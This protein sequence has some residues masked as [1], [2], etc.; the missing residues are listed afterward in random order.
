MAKNRDTQQG[1]KQEKEFLKELKTKDKQFLI[2]L[3][4]LERER[5]AKHIAGLFRDTATK[6]TE[7]SDKIDTFDE[8]FRMVNKPVTGTDGDIPTYVS[9]LS[10]VSNEVIHSNIMNV[11]FSPAQVGR[12]LPTEEGDIPKVKK[13]D[14]FMDWSMK[15]ELHLFEQTDRL[16]HASTK[17]GETPYLMHWVKEYGTAIKR[18]PIINLLTGEPEIDEVTSLPKFTETKERKLLYN[19]PRLETFSRKDYVQPLNA[20]MDKLPDWEMMKHRITYDQYLRE[21]LQGKCYKGSLRDIKD[22][23]SE[24]SASTEKEDFEGDTIPVGKWE[25]EFVTFYGRLRLKSVKT[26]ADD[27]TIMEEEELE[28]EFIAVVNVG[29]VSGDEILCSLRENKFPLKMRPIGIDYFV[30]DDEGRRAG[31]GVFELMEGIQTGYDALYNQYLFGVIQSNSPVLFFSPLGNQRNEPVKIRHGYMYPTSD[32][33]AI[34][35]IQFPQPNQTIQN[36]L[37]LVQSWAQILFGISAFSAGVESTIDP[38]APAKKAALV[39]Q[40]GNVRLNAIIKRKNKTLKDIFKRWYLLYNENMPP[41]KF[42]R[43]AGEDRDNPYRF[44]KVELSDF[45]LQ[46]IPDFELT[47]NILN[48][49]KALE[50]NKRLAIYDKLIV[51]PFF[52]PQTSEGMIALHSL[53]KWFIE[54]MDEI[55]LSAFLPNLPVEK[56]LTPEEENARFLQGDEIEPKQGEPHAAHL[57]VHQK[58]LISQFIPDDIKQIAVVHIKRTMQILQEEVTQKL[59]LGQAGI[60]QQ[61]FGQSLQEP[62]TNTPTV[63]TPIQQGGENAVG[64]RAQVSEGR[65]SPAKLSVSRVG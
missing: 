59:V 3:S 36:I 2:D 64:T 31:L 20:V 29:A 27:K 54:G 13:L 10:T 4:L 58:M 12:V 53:T 48:S 50:M 21:E 37:E 49:N 6:Q 8:T 9:P 25:K 56:S 47:G 16:F 43:I 33:K 22:W 7:I 55:G 45:A 63:K 38:D 61:A 5:V 65:P 14:T 15:N 41:N 51:N 26:R 24:D 44:E 17:N 42:M 18:D 52:N 46:S 19:G 1:T 35:T 11:F 28:D 39:V 57:K 30:P 23:G 62:Q 34:T 32:T 60:D 40:Q